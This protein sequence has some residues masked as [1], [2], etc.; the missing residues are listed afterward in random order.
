ML[1]TCSQMLRIKNKTTQ[2]MLSINALRP[3]KH[4][5]PKDLMIFGR[6]SWVKHHKDFT[7]VIIFVRRQSM[8]NEI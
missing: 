5:L 7:F 3:L 6:R 8:K 2:K 1:G 4:Y